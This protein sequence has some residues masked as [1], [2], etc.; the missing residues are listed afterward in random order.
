MSKIQPVFSWQKYEGLEEDQR[1]QFQ[2]QLQQQHI[3]VANGLNSTVDDSSTFLTA[4]QTGFTWLGAKAIW[5][6]TIATTAW[7]AGGTVNTI[8]LGIDGNFT[9]IAM[10]CCISD[11][12]TA[13]S[14][15]LQMPHVDV[16]VAANQI[17]ITR[18]GTNVFLRSGGT[19]RSAFSGYLTVNFIRT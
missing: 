13:A 8:P 7:T 12:A 3:V 1:T 5:T 19:D 9:V 4:R 15:T 17:S 14:N 16:A 11:G 18:Q 6:K 10:T 2:F